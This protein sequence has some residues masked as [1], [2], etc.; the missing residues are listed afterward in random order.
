MKNIQHLIHL[1]HISPIS[2]D[3]MLIS[4]VGLLI[5]IAVT[6]LVVMIGSQL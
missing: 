5:A 4:G 2:R 1:P 6:T 3:I